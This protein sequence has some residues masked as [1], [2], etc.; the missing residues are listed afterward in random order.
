MADLL[1]RVIY[2]LVSSACYVFLRLHNN[3]KVCNLDRIPDARPFVVAV[4]HC[5]NLDP[6]V[7]GAVF[8]IRLRYLAKE[9][10]FQGSRIFAW[11]ITRLGAIPVS[12]EGAQRAGGALRAFLS[13]LQSGESVLLFPEGS[14]SQDGKVKPLEGGVGL[15]ALKTGAPV[16][17][18]YV[19]GTFEAMPIGSSKI[20]R[21]TISMTLGEALYPSLLTEGLSPKEARGRF[22]KALEESFESMEASALRSK[23]IC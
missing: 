22:L 10:L 18:V 15:L 1:D 6:V 5:S 19:S 16:V 23:T 20:G 3:L 2:W 21:Q 4:N 12:R 8:P 11:L 7:V 9:E 14:R 17:P 13:L